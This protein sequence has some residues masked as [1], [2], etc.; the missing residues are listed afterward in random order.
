M[1]KRLLEILILFIFVTGRSSQNSNYWGTYIGE[2]TGLDHD[3]YGSLYIGDKNSLIIKDFNFNGKAAAFFNVGITSGDPSN[4]GYRIADETG[5]FT[6]LRKYVDKDIVLN[7]PKILSVQD[8]KWIA[9]WSEIEL[10]SYGQ[11]IFKDNAL[12]SLK[13]PAIKSLG[14]LQGHSHDISAKEVILL[15]ERTLNIK[16]LIYDG[17]APEL[18]YYA[19]NTT[20]I[21]HEGATQVHDHRGS[22]GTLLKA[23]GEDFLITLPDNLTWMDFRWFSLY[24]I[25]FTVDLG[26]VRIPTS[27]DLY[28]PPYNAYKL[29]QVLLNEP[30]EGLDVF[31]TKIK[32]FEF[33]INRIRSDDAAKMKI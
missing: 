5:K 33:N 12:K 9:V 20:K 22:Y 7:L 11:I 2:L 13:I 16:H 25:A 6:A 23:N 32:K 15:T 27:E 28:L 10:K 21:T 19:G 4:Q 29:R 30:K 8:L 24:C 18:Y 1:A 3:V 17:T 26:S 14:P 31:N